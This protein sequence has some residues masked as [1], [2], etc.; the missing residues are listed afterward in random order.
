MEYCFW[1][2]ILFCSPNSADIVPKV[3]PVNMSKVA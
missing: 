2:M 1:S 3:S